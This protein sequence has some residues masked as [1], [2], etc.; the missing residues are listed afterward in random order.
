MEGSP[1]HTWRILKRQIPFVPDLGIT[2]T[3][4]ENTLEA[5][6]KTDSVE[7][8][9]HIRGEYSPSNMKSISDLG[10][11][12]HTWR[13]PVSSTVAVVSVRITST[14]VEN[15]LGYDPDED[16]DE[17]HLHIRGEYKMLTILI[18]R[19]LGSPPHTWRIQ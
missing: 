18:M 14:Y 3:Y 7:D 2:S 9:L 4:V 1:P 10:S 19:P 6:S 13:I 16:S 17:D 11:P 15:T 8:H 5:I 12:P